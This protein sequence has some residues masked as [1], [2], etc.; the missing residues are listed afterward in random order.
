MG[1]SCSSLDVCGN[2][3]EASLSII[4]GQHET[5]TGV[6]NSHATDPLVYTY[7]YTRPPETGIFADN[8]MQ[9]HHIQSIL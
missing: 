1:V 9:M 6:D 4:N 7:I 3:S 8:G 2:L 5:S